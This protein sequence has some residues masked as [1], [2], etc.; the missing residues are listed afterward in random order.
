MRGYQ[1]QTKFSHPPLP[2]LTEIRQ[3][4]LTYLTEQ[5][6]HN[7]DV[8]LAVACQ[9]IT[10]HTISADWQSVPMPCERRPGS[11]YLMRDPITMSVYPEFYG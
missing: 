9:S 11:A 3:R 5:G 8:P 10:L 1:L 2:S 6:Y 4:C 7:S